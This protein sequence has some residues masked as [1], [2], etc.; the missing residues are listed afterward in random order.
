M[1]HTPDL[2]AAL[3]AALHEMLAT[4]VDTTCPSTFAADAARAA[5]AKAQGDCI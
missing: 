4:Y 2:L 5:I 1:S 3:L